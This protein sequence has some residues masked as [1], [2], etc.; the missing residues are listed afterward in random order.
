M[1]RLPGNVLLGV[2]LEGLGDAYYC[3][4]ANLPYGDF[5]PFSGER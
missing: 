3:L 5:Y 4:Q 1:S 2:F